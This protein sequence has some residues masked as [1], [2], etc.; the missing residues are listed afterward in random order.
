MQKV[1]NPVPRVKH[2]DWLSKAVREKEDTHKQMSITDMLLK[3]PRTPVVADEGAE[4][5][6]KEVSPPSEVDME[7]AFP[8]GADRAAQGKGM[9]GRPRVQRFFRGAEE[10][11]RCAVPRSDMHIPYL[12]LSVRILRLFALL[13]ARSLN[14]RLF[15]FHLSFLS[16]RFFAYATSVRS[17]SAGRGGPCGPHGGPP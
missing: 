15:N 13:F 6:D 4:G 8:G 9:K 14:A 17:L 10:G 5:A 1:P 12:T 7:D 2:P 11:V 16:W 3:A